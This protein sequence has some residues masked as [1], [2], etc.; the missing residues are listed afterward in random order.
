MIRPRIPSVTLTAAVLTVALLAA[1]GARA[2][3]APAWT[4]DAAKSRLTFTGRQM[5]VP[6]KGEFKKFAAKI[7]FDAKNL[8]GSAVEVTIDT[9][10]AST[11][12]GDIDKELKRT[13]W[14]QVDKFPTAR[15][16]ASRFRAKGGDAFEA[17]GKLTIRDVTRDVVMPFTLTTSGDGK[18]MTAKAKGELKIKRLDYGI[19]REQWADTDVIAN[20]VV[21]RFDLTASHP[22]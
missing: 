6:T 17:L 3:D 20:E 16:V 4:V 18:T 22:K 8:D 21:I 2:A 14:F 1:P 9:A 5:R 15:F 12:N 10:T 7:R 13:L 11:G 19:G